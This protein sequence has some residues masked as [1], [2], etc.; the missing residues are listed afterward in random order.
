MKGGRGDKPD[1]PGQKVKAR[2]ELP[3]SAVLSRRV[4]IIN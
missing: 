1:V 2:Q 4:E 3:A